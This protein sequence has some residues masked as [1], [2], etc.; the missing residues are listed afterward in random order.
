LAEGIGIGGGGQ[1]VEETVVLGA[2]VE[3]QKRATI[4]IWDDRGILDNVL[5]TF[6][7]SLVRQCMRRV[8]GEEHGGLLGAFCADAGGAITITRS[9]LT[10]GE[11]GMSC[12]AAAVADSHR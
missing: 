12:S 8:K 5:F 9:S 1:G 3:D 10:V 4:M 2:R 11:G 7:Y 6:D